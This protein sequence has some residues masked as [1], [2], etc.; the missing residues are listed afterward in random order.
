[1]TL[2]AMDKLIFHLFSHF[3]PAKKP[4]QLFYPPL[5]LFPI[6]P[7]ASFT[8]F[9]PSEISVCDEDGILGPLRFPV[10]TG[11]PLYDFSPPWLR[12]PSPD[13]HG[14]Q[15][16]SPPPLATFPFFSPF[17]RINTPWVQMTPRRSFLSSSWA[18]PQKQFHSLPPPSP[19]L[20][21]LPSV[22]RSAFANPPE[23]GL[24]LH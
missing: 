20:L 19:T 15:P 7:L 3:N 11:R 12:V 16:P 6:S 18:F 2:P 5:T 17:P 22:E 21:T 8:I 10:I 1:L 13:M 23:S 9:S 14:F 4:D 24:A